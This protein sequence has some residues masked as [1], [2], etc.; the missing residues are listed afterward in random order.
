MRDRCK[1]GV[2]RE[3]LLQPED[4]GL[5]VRVVCSRAAWDTGQDRDGE[6]SKAELKAEEACR[7]VV[8]TLRI[9]SGVGQGGVSKPVCLS[10]SGLST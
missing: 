5:R 2:D 9:P 4:L 10:Q 3:E 7:S 6:Q 8:S 1:R